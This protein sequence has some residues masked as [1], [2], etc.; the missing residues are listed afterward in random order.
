MSQLRQHNILRQIR[1]TSS[2]HPN[3][4]DI[5][6]SHSITSST[7][8]RLSILPIRIPMTL[9]HRIRRRTPIPI[10][11]PIPIPITIQN[12]ILNYNNSRIH[13]QPMRIRIRIPIHMI[14]HHR[15]HRLRLRKPR[16]HQV[17]Q[18]HSISIT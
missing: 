12:H 9:H 4:H 6:I 7:S 18:C 3:P 10:S 2:R 16:L 14:R 1:H 17:P 13:I 8:N 15:H 5:S 11:I